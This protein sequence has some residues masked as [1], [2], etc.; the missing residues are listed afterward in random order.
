[1]AE[2]VDDVHDCMD[3]GGRAT[4][5]QLP[6]MYKC[7]EELDVRERPRRRRIGRNL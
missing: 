3:A 2:L 7:R 1:V 6:R 4:Q 5:E